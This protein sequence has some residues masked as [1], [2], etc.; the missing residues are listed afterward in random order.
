[1][2]YQMSRLLEGLGSQQDD[3]D[4]QLLQQVNNFIALRPQAAWLERFCCGGK[5]IPPMT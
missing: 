3:R 5:I 2:A 1:M 4:Q